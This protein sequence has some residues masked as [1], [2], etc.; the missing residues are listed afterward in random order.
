M[1]TTIVTPINFNRFAKRL[2]K[3][4][5]K[6]SVDLSLSSAQDILSKTLGFKNQFE[7]KNNFT[8]PNIHFVEINELKYQYF[9]YR[10]RSFLECDAEI[11]KIIFDDTFSLF[12]ERSP[13]IKNIHNSIISIIKKITDI[14]NMDESIQKIFFAYPNNKF[15]MM[16]K[17]YKNLDFPVS[18]Y[19]LSDEQKNIRNSTIKKLESHPNLKDFWGKQAPYNVSFFLN[20]IYLDD[21]LPLL[22]DLFSY[23]IINIIDAFNENKDIFLHTNELAYFIKFEHEKLIFL[24][25]KMYKK[26]YYLIHTSDLNKSEYQ[27]K[28]LNEQ[29]VVIPNEILGK[30]INDKIIDTID[31]NGNKNCI[32]PM[33]D[34]SLNGLM[35]RANLIQNPSNFRIAEIYSAFDFIHRIEYNYLSSG[36]E[37]LLGDFYTI[38]EANKKQ[39]NKGN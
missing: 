21:Y 26:N 37:N 23:S 29:Y 3:I 22:N 19:D 10:F 4:S 27:I 2:K 33:H 6:N 35:S 36:R 11:S 39:L 18:I 12:K 9:L 28:S 17:N 7:F 25:K 20:S 1:L 16:I 13:S 5:H 8:D 38:E 24:D 34:S 32:T 30:T 31:F 14:A 15:C